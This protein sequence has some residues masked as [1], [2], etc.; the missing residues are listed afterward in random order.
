LNEESENVSMQDLHAYLHKIDDSAMRMSH[1]IEDLLNYSRL[2][3]TAEAF[4]TT[5]LNEVMQEIIREFE[6]EIQKKKAVIHIGNLPVLKAVPLRMHQLFHNLLSNSLK[7][8]RRDVH[9]EISINS[10]PLNSSEQ[11]AVPGLEKDLAY[12]KISFRD[13]GIGFKQEFAEKAFTIFQRLNGRS[14]YDGTG[15][16]LAIC[17][18]I[19]TNHGGLISVNSKENEGTEFTIYL[20]G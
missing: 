17:R 4:T 2:Q 8:I 5:D 20:P 6:L 3:N 12:F 9:P 16:G 14:E 13:N 11:K 18:K 1:L 10:R 7:F 15:I 19:V